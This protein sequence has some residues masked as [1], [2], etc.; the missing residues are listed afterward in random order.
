MS[1]CLI[2]SG[3]ADVETS[4][5]LS[6]DAGLWGEVAA[7]EVALAPTPLE[8]QPSAY[9]QASWRDRKRGD[10]PAIA[11]KAIH[12]RDSIAVQLAWHQA[13]PNR[14]ISDYNVYADA[15]AVLFPENGTGATLETMGSSDAAV[16]GW[17]WRAGT[18][19]PFE[20][21]AQ[22]IGTVERSKEHAVQGA[23]RW[24]SDSWQVV[25]ARNLDLPG[26]RLRDVA[27]I[28]VAF[29][30]WHGGVGERAGLKSYSPEFHRLGLMQPSEAGAL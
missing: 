23:A 3:F 2:Q 15:C 27:D 29:A 24:V 26:P 19:D 10:V 30:V 9:I 25:L 8:R 11:V 14:S 20:I 7:T 28:P 1:G 12:T 22:G 18:P 13:T 6:P 4:V 16:V 17:Y 5:L 21:R